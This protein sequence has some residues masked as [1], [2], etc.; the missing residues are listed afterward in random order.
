MDGLAL[1]L[2]N[3]A[4]SLYLYDRKEN[5]RLLLLS[6]LPRTPL[7]GEGAHHQEAQEGRDVRYLK[8]VV[9]WTRPGVFFCCNSRCDISYIGIGRYIGLF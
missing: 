2:H 9:G 1:F 6:I 5:G 4:L 8:N 7:D 3:P